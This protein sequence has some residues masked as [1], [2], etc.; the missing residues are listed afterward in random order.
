MEKLTKELSD[1][2]L[3]QIQNS[4]EVTGVYVF[5]NDTKIPLRIPFFNDM[6]LKDVYVERGHLVAVSD[7]GKVYEWK[8]GW[9][10]ARLINLPYNVDKV[11]PTNDYFYF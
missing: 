3:N 10:D 9:S 4:K 2:H 8:K 1:D 11:T 5:G 7:N 6:I